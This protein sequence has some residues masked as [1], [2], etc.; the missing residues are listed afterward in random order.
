MRR[1]F[2]EII[3][4]FIGKYILCKGRA[5][6]AIVLACAAA[7]ITTCFPFVPAGT[8]SMAADCGQEG[9]VYTE[10]STGSEIGPIEE[11][12]PAEGRVEGQDSSGPIDEEED[13][14][15]GDTVT[16]QAASEGTKEAGQLRLEEYL[17]DWTTI[18]Y[19][20]E[21][22]G[23]WQPLAEDKWHPLYE[24]NW[25][26]Q[27]GRKKD[28]GLDPEEMILLHIGYKI[29]AGTVSEAAPQAR[30][31]FPPLANM[32]EEEVR[33]NNEDNN[34]LYQ[35]TDPDKEELY[36]DGRYEIEEEWDS[37]GKTARRE[38]V[39]TFNEDACLRCGKTPA[40]RTGD[41]PQE[42]EGFFELFIK[43]GDLITPGTGPGPVCVLEW[44][45]E[46]DLDTTV[47]FDSE[48]LA[49]YCGAD[50]E[51]VAAEDAGR[52]AAGEL[53]AEGKDYAVTVTYTEKAS[54]PAGV[55]LEA[56]EVTKA[57]DDKTS[58][59]GLYLEKTGEAL[60]VRTDQLTYIRFFDIRLVDGSGQKVDI[61]APVDVKIE[62]TGK[63][64]SQDL[65]VIHFPDGG[66]AGDVL[67]NV[68]AA[69]AEGPAE[70]SALSFEADGFSVYALVE[71][72][73]PVETE[74]LYVTGLDEL[75]EDVPFLLS[76]NGT[77]KYFTNTLISSGCFAETELSSDA[78][79][80][81]FEGAGSAGEYYLCTYVD[82]Q[83]KYVKNTS[84]N[85]V[86]LVDSGGTALELSSAGTEGKFYFKHGSAN[87]WLQ[88]SNGGGGIRFYTD[89]NNAANSQISIT[90]ASSY[91][92]EDDPY[93]L[94]GVITG[95]VYDSGSL[96]CTALMQD[97]AGAGSAAAQDMVKLDTKDR[98]SS[99]FVPADS[100][101]TEWT[102]TSAGGDKYYI[103]AGD[104]RYLAVRDGSAS[105][106]DEPSADSLF[107]VVPG[108][109]AHAGCYSFTA[110]GHTLAMAGS[111]DD[112][113][114]TGTGSRDG[115]IWFRFAEKSSLS[116]GD[117]LV[118]SAKKVSAYAP[119]EEVVLYTRK[120]NGANY[121]FY[122]VDYD[123]SLIRCYD[124]GDV[125]KWAGSQYQTAVWTLTEHTRAD[126]QGN[127]VPNGYYELRNTYSGRYIQP[128]L[129][130]DTPFSDQEAFLNLDGRYYQ[131]EYTKIRCWDDTYYSY[132][133]LKADL[134]AHKA[135][136]CPPSQADDFY[137]A[138][139]KALPASLTEVETV[140][141]NAFG[142]TVKMVDFNNTIVSGRDSVQ[143]DYFG[144]DT[145]KAG[146]LTTDI[147]EASGYPVSTHN[148]M[149]L[150]GL[151]AGGT[152]ANGLFI[153]S[154]YDESGYIEFDSTKNYAYLNGS[155]FEVYDQLGT[156]ERTPYKPTS[157]HG[158]FMPYNQLT[159]P[160]TGEPWPYSDMYSNK[161]TVTGDPLPEDDP[162]YGEGLHEIPKSK[163]DY[164]FGMEMS[165]AFTQTPDGTDAWGNDIIFEFSG[166]DD[167]WLY[168]DGELVLDLGGVHSAMSGSVNFR[169]GTVTGRG[170]QTRTLREIFEGNYRQRNPGASN[171][172]VDTY[173]QKYFEGD[174]TVFAPYS[175]HT[176]N[177][178]Y[179]ERGAGASNLHMRLNLAAVKPGEVMLS[180]KV[181]GSEDVDYDLMEFPYQILYRTQEDIDAGRNWRRLAQNGHEPAVTYAGS[182][183]P[184]R[185]ADSYTPPGASS[186]CEDVFF[187]KAGEKAAIAMPADTVEYKVV[188]CSVNMDIF[189]AV[190]ANS[191][192]LSEDTDTGRKDYAAPPASIEDRPEVAFE[193]E[194]DP[195]SLRTL[196][197]TKVLWDEEGNR[198]EGYEPDPTTFDFR[199]SMSAQG[200]SSL[201]PVRNKEYFVR[202]IDNNYCRWD[203][204]TQRFVS[205]GISSYADLS[206][207]LDTLTGAEKA[208]VIF[209]T[210]NNGAV[211]R[212][213]GGYSVEFRGLPVDSS[214]QVIERE[215]EIPE[216]YELVKYERDQGSYLS[217]EEPNKGTIRA[218][219]DPHILVHNKRG[220][221]LTVDK[222]WSDADYMDSHDD[223]YIGIYLKGPAGGEPSLL[224]GTLRRLKSPSVSLYYYFDQLEAGASFEDYEAC[225]VV[226][227]DPVCDADGNVVSYS[228]AERVTDGGAMTVGG[229]PKDKEH[230][231]GFVYHA[232]YT[233]GQSEGGGA[234]NVRTDTIANVRQG[235]KLIKTDWEGQALPGA[236]FTLE[237][238]DGSPAGAASYTS[239]GDGLITTAYLDPGRTYTLEETAA[240]AGFRMPS[241][242]WSVKVEDGI[243]SVSGD[244]GSYEVIQADGGQMAVVILKN[245]GFSLQAVKED[246]ES[247]APLEGAVFA[248]Y[249]QVDAAGGKVRDQ[250]P[251]PGYEALRTGA[252]GMIPGITSALKEGTYYLLETSPPPGHQG[253]EGYLVFTIRDGTVEVP[254][255][256][257]SDDPA[258]VVILN[259]TE[260]LPV[261]DWLSFKEQDGHTAYRIAIPNEPAE[262]QALL[263][264]T[265][266]PGIRPVLY[267]VAALAFTGTWMA[268]RKRARQVIAEAKKQREI[269]K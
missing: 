85:L 72:P 122:I 254:P 149:S 7:L 142:I 251:V 178:Y 73:E 140:D 68:E 203:P 135:V 196:T 69:E 52:P 50:D 261:T 195:E 268:R 237:D 3:K 107:R 38:L 181:T 198:L 185:F 31:M 66:G 176:M 106:E 91:E 220:W 209:E 188:E 22:K 168:V 15:A 141:N 164:F 144:K 57:R 125:V 37:N 119:V 126:G 257:D 118:Y 53:R 114:F 130:E 19:L 167:F 96:F 150:G 240:P 158:Q 216:G 16:G 2:W 95:I 154:V 267:L 136:P 190:K 221:G 62:L 218:S 100:D 153:Q 92:T 129:G 127:P 54:L 205:L 165:A 207:Y 202:D 14:Q 13:L 247:K 21:G 191:E 101:I 34:Y 90:Y 109:G 232:G 60:G 8:L 44:N 169:T 63:E 27:Q 48:K 137:F 116:E 98:E 76:Y 28:R 10:D 197:V 35:G 88:H 113:G 36:L 206:G 163:A 18:Y 214:F 64:D 104:G 103:T 151:F 227:T 61:A 217:E 87:K 255:Y 80:W 43:A 155:E 112:R 172:E 83:K 238:E 224:E 128:M 9:P 110:G 234:G 162:R 70:S 184:V 242:A 11:D 156:T 123:G 187:L 30:F 186:P 177:I 256:V 102:F 223:I 243:V 121:D 226:L 105:L 222:A 260:D 250:R 231:E 235:I 236:V 20:P 81:Y 183:R 262:D 170:G 93:G 59:Y 204:V 210:S 99:L 124:E 211:S 131:E 120:W 145:D 4:K 143:T 215:D 265:G 115:R 193:N 94:D 249:R 219:Q 239:G 245:K 51:D 49:A 201:M 161:T 77:G 233:K 82:G 41:S 180:K 40:N 175:P 266:G 148:N 133:G 146:L 157:S 134:D 71:A 179:M 228:T 173:L 258:S 58:A 46:E 117:Y 23:Y 192:L 244:D 74:V 259:N 230:Q 252:D 42:L 174:S 159:D 97:D 84:G 45:D 67:E 212:I 200:P 79:E 171:A 208:S 86:G 26:I 246:A 248:L 138:R 5:C 111:D 132:I 229:C 78:A 241:I 12:A 56:A 225:E 263:P 29:P 147:D 65:S 108:T 17:T 89:K 199:I 75:A 189:K 269:S 6:T 264:G 139:I 160:A 24:D 25:D 1:A 33:F 253:L 182:K 55:S 213:P 39:L 152:K 32:T 166:D 47:R 194:V